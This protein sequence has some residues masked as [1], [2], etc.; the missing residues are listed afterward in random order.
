MTIKR[1]SFT[2]MLVAYILIVFGGFVA[3]SKSGMGCG[4]EWPLCN[5]AVIPSL[6]GKT[7]VEFTHRFIGAILVVLSVILLIKVWRSNLEKPARSIAYTMMGLLVLQCLLGALVVLLE[8][9]TFVI[10][11]HLIVAMVFFYCVI[12]LWHASTPVS[13]T[14]HTPKGMISHLNIVIG[15]L[16]LTI[17]LGAYIKHDYYG[18]TCGWLG[19][20]GSLLPVTAG[21]ILQTLHRVLA[22]ISALYI[23]VLSILAY[24]K[25]WGQHLRRRLELA[26]FIVFV[27]LCAGVMTILSFIALPWAVLHLAIGTLLLA[28]LF[29][30]QVY[31]VFQQDYAYKDKVQNKDVSSI[32]RI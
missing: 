29:E 27:Q 31:I 23:L 2:T 32:S 25:G 28:V 16:L 24:A 13:K 18:L 3:S 10:A 9:P 19:C 7:L 15:L 17:G 20:R 4:P 8:L 21:Q 14:D 6:Q 1:L 11:I 5:G 26:G 12:W 22:V 30:A